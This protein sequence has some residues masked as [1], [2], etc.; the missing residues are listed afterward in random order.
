MGLFNIKLVDDD[1]YKNVVEDSVLTIDKD[2]KTITIEGL[3][4]TFEYEQSAIEQT[5]LEAGGVLPLYGQY[6]VD[7]FR[8]ITAKQPKTRKVATNERGSANG[9]ACSS[10]GMEW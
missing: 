1:F 2:K 8:R 7:V 6:G 3:N 9:A 5:L 4:K 10:E